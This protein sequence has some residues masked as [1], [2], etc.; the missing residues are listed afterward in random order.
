MELLVNCFSFC[1]RRNR[2]ARIRMHRN[3]R[4]MRNTNNLRVAAQERKSFSRGCLRRGAKG[5]FEIL[6]CRQWTS[7]RACSVSLPA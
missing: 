1:N 2:I 6:L 4:V 5:Y 7:G 3:P